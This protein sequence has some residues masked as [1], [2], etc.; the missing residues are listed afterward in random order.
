M[1]L[2]AFMSNAAFELKVNNKVNNIVKNL[3]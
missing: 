1:T 3:S 2:L